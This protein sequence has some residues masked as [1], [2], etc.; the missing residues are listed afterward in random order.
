MHASALAE[1]ISIEDCKGLGRPGGD[2]SGVT[3]REEEAEPGAEVENKSVYSFTRVVTF[4]TPVQDQR[5]NRIT[6]AT[7][8]RV[9]GPNFPRGYPTGMRA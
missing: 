1:V 8:R 4:A 9:T 6:S 2:A 7:G 3:S 5:S